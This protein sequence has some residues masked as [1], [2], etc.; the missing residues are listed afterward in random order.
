V[1][2]N[3]ISAGSFAANKGVTNLLATTHPSQA[4]IYVVGDSSSYWSN[5]STPNTSVTST[6]SG[7]ASG[8]AMFVYAPLSTVTV[9]TTPACV[10]VIGISVT[11][12]GVGT[13]AGGFIGYNTNVTATAITEDLG[14]LSLPLSTSLGVFRVQQYIE[15]PAANTLPSPDPTSGC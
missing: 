10:A 3:G 8:Q 12:S 13:L 1:S 6:A 5:S 14:L 2:H 7:L 4:Q 9:S 11:C 15:C